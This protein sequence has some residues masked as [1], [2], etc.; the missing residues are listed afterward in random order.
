MSDSLFCP[1][2]K[3]WVAALPEEKIRQALVQK[4]T[5]RLGYSLGSIALEK[6]LEQLPHLQATRSLPRRRADLIVFAKDL[7]PQHAFYPLLLVE[8]KAAP[9]THKV[10]RQ[11]IG[12]NQFVGA[13]FIA[14]VNET[15]TYLGYYHP[16]YQDFQFEEGLIMYDLL[17]KRAHTLNKFPPLEP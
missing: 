10:L 14:A 16:H 8:C 15:T 7:H 12:Y 3:I 9:L 1:L 11:L 4:M 13:Y 6:N 17:L 2:R 5:Q